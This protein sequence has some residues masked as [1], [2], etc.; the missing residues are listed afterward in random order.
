[1]NLSVDKDMSW[2]VAPAAGRETAVKMAAECVQAVD[3][4]PYVYSYD[5]IYFIY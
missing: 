4:R 1:M 5:L 2:E 3:V